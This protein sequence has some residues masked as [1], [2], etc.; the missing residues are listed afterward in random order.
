MLK[1]LVLLVLVFQAFSE[2]RRVRLN[3]LNEIPVPI[4]KTGDTA[5]DVTVKLDSLSDN[6]AT[7]PITVELREITDLTQ[8]L[9]STVLA[10]QTCTFSSN[11]CTLT[12]VAPG[13]KVASRY[14]V[15]LSESNIIHSVNAKVDVAVTNSKG[16]I[17]LSANNPAMISPQ[18]AENPGFKFTVG[19]AGTWTTKLSLVSTPAPTIT[20]YDL[21]LW[22]VSSNVLTSVATKSVT[23]VGS[24]S[25]DIATAGDYYLT[26]ALQ[27][28]SIS[29]AQY[30]I[31]LEFSLPNVQCASGQFFD[32]KAKACVACSTIA[33]AA[34]TTTVV[35]G[36][37]CNA[38]FYW[39]EAAC[40]A[41]PASGCPTVPPTAPPKGPEQQ[42]Q[43]G[44]GKQSANLQGSA[45]GGKK[46]KL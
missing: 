3:Y 44:N 16:A 34:G 17:T 18:G 5:G 6:D 26:V 8:P 40:A 12:F 21:T 29:S 13:L 45:P 15:R 25:F 35:D 1:T 39:K 10:T 32:R 42:N 46:G 27:I 36:C 41:C 38:S 11:A 20:S 19:T 33:N 43:G 28:S 2:E 37:D 7:V 9:T 24:V 31:G 30:P 4:L 22:S 14:T 23:A